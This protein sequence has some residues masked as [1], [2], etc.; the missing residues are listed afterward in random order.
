M[1]QFVLRACEVAQS[2]AVVAEFLCHLD[3]QVGVHPPFQE[4]GEAEL[5]GDGLLQ[6]QHPHVVVGAEGPGPHYLAHRDPADHGLGVRV[7]HGHHGGGGVA[8]VA[9]VEFVAVEDVG[10]HRRVLPVVGHEEVVAVAEAVGHVGADDQA[11][12]GEDEFGRGGTHARGDGLDGD[13]PGLAGVGDAAVVGHQRVPGTLVI[14]PF[15]GSG[16]RGWTSWG[17]GVGHRYVLVG[18]RGGGGLVPLARVATC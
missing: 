9:R 1:G 2:V 14:D 8:G 5:L 7:V 15:P 18:G 6:C 3:A 16:R 10:P 13:R 4:P 17:R 12:R 11:E